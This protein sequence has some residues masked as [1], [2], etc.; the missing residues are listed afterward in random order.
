MDL[1]DHGET[2]L[3][4]IVSAVNLQL[5]ELRGVWMIMKMLGLKRMIT[6]I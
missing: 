1:S 3:I 5:D 6:M 2:E 4:S